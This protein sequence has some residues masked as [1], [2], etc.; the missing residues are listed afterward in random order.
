MEQMK[1]NY[2]KDILAI[3]LADLQFGQIYVEDF[4]EIVLADI[5]REFSEI[6]EMFKYLLESEEQNV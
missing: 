5:K 4:A 1:G 3:R 2:L 6:A